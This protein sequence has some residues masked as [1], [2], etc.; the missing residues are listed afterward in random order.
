MKVNI[1]AKT[2]DTSH[3]AKKMT[4]KNVKKLYGISPED[5]NLRIKIFLASSMELK[6]DRVAFET[7]LSRLNDD[8]IKQHIYIELVLWEKFL[9]AMTLEGLQKEYNKAIRKC[10]VFVMLFSTKVGKYSHE[11]FD[12][13]YSNFKKSGKPLIFVYSRSS[14]S[15]LESSGKTLKSADLFKEKLS[16]IGHFYTRYKNT[17]DLLNHFSNQLKKIELEQ[18]KVKK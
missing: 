1:N 13:A 6:E 10:D 15:A 12:S 7:N 14:S 18:L 8:Y 16:S 2:I 9:D 17:E 5:I 4:I 3:V 11:E